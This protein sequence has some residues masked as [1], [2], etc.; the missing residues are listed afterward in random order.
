MAIGAMLPPFAAGARAERAATTVDYV[1][2]RSVYVD[3]GQH[4]GL[5]E[6][7]SLEV[8]REGH[9]IAW[10][11][12]SF[13]SSHRAACDTLQTWAVVQPGDAASFTPHAGDARDASGA[14][15]V[16]AGSDSAARPGPRAHP[17][18]RAGG[19]H[20]RIGARYLGLTSD[21]GVRLSQPAVDARIEG[22]RLGGSPLD[23]ALDFRGRRFVSRRPGTV[24]VTRDRGFVYRASVGVRD[25]GDRRRFTVGRLL[26]PALSPVNLFDGALAETRSAR[27]DFGLFAGTQ[28]DPARLAVSGHIVQGGGYASW[29]QP[30]PAI[31]RYSV[32]GGAI[33]SSDRGHPN[34]DFGF[35]QA[36]YADRRLTASLQQEVDYNRG[37]KRDAGSAALTSTGTDLNLAYRVRAATPLSAASPELSVFAGLDS[38]RNV[39]LYRDHETPET[40]FLD[41]YRRGAW[42]GGTLDLAN[43]VR[44]GAEARTSSVAGEADQNG[45]ST[46]LDAY[47]LGAFNLALR[48]RHARISGAGLANQLTSVGAGIDPLEGAHLELAGGTRRSEDVGSSVADEVRW[49]SA[50]LELMLARR[51]Y[52]DLNAQAERGGA[53]P[54][55][56]AQLGLS[57]RF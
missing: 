51:A 44:L 14:G 48:A 35:L 26:S 43:H 42:A 10:L 56:Q 11:R 23:V 8:T 52:L 21:G 40:R 31:A 28:P 3:A 50:A 33:T 32:S 38:R 25:S 29:H 2:G 30:A 4:D 45:W 46:R 7:D 36:A 34:R 53:D 15:N 39:W 17:A 47:R 54:T 16:V 9:T 22:T 57:W 24:S 49:A 19:L 12:V 37:W 5:R 55:R 1:T 6:G 27:W 41:R 20:G 13:L 18:A